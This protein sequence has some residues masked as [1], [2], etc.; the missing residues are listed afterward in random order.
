MNR[1]H[2]ENENVR[3]IYWMHNVNDGYSLVEQC[4]DIFYE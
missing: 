4:I 3:V 1:K 2:V